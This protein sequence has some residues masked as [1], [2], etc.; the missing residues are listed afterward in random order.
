LIL[1]LQDVNAFYG[2]SHVLHG[3]SLGIG[4]G[5]AV[6]LLGRNGAGKTSTLLSVMGFLKPRPGKVT[7]KG[8]DI[9]GLSPNRISRAGI[10]FVCQERGVDSGPC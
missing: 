7:Y 5:E 10:G 6:S 4:E 2:A 9:T 3:I 1:Q 8:R